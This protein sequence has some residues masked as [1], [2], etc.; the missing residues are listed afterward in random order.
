[1]RNNNIVFD[2]SSSG[3]AILKLPMLDVCHLSELANQNDMGI[4]QYTLNGIFRMMSNEATY[5]E[6]TWLDY[7]Y[8]YKVTFKLFEDKIF[9][10]IFFLGDESL[11]EETTFLKKFVELQ[12]DFNDFLKDIYLSLSIMLKKFGLL[13]YKKVSEVENF[14]IYEYLYL[15]AKFNN[16]QILPEEN[17]D[18][19]EWTNKH[20]FKEEVNIL[21]LNMD[22]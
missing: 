3:V 13:G 12:I 4:I 8:D 5:F 6:A 20:S 18:D 16:I 7:L 2:F 17:N 1:M 11:L 10:N 14:P 9:V 22:F 21:Q 15:K 19:I